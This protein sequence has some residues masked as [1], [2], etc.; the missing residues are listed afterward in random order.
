[1][2]RTKIVATIGPASASG[3][4]ISQMVRAGLNCARLNFSHGSHNEHRRL[5]RAIR[6]AG[7]K[8]HEPVL[9]MADMRGPKFRLGNLRVPVVLKINQK[10]VLAPESK[11]NEAGVIPV[12]FFGLQ[13]CLRAGERVLIDD[14]KIALKITRVSK[15]KIF[16]TVAEGGLVSARKGVN[17][18]DSKLD[19]LS[20]TDKD[21]ADL[22][23]CIKLG[24]DAVALS[25]VHSADDIKQ[26]RALI[27]KI[28]KTHK[29][30]SGSPTKIIAKIENQ[31]AVA[32]MEKII[33]VA[34]GIMVARGDMGV[35]LPAAQVPL[36]QKRL[37]DLCNA[38]AKPVIVATQMLD[39][40]QE[41]IRP[42]RAEVSDIANAVIDHTDAV[43]LSNET[44]VGKFPALSVRTMAEIVMVTEASTYDDLPGAVIR[45]K[46]S[47]VDE[48]IV[49]LSRLLAENVGA[50]LILAA[51]LTGETGRMISHLRSEIP[52]LVAT[53]DARVQRQL[54][55]S[56]GVKPFI[57]PVCKTIE[58]LIKKSMVYIKKEKFANKG[59]KMIVVAGEPV[60]EAGHVNL[61]EVREVI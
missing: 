42:T 45:K 56:W 32:N 12:D 44:A 11:T 4:I 28:E 49:Q 15:D 37:I 35:E 47:Q 33:A 20:L 55:L 43:M 53:H 54:N 60:G 34:D 29:I 8:Y 16:A 59:D 2:K 22:E 48:S 17:L 23:F 25:F 6:V 1:M 21:K 40:M 36:V 7:K 27:T 24:V 52:V 5:Y 51:S 46:G 18:P 3:K 31:S 41:H 38:A 30:N 9:I 50:K 10:V 13:K 61:V 14:G 58:E 19:M 39:S 57:L 26:A